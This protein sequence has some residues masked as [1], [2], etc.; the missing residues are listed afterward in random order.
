[1]ITATRRCGCPPKDIFLSTP[2]SPSKPCCCAH[3]SSPQHKPSAALPE[4]SPR[5]EVKSVSEITGT[6]SPYKEIEAI[7]ND[8]R[9][10]LRIQKL[11]LQ[12]EWDPPCDCGTGS[13]EEDRASATRPAAIESSTSA[14]SYSEGVVFRKA[15]EKSKPSSVHQERI[16]EPG[17]SSRRT[18]T[19]VSH[20]DGET[21]PPGIVPAAALSEEDRREKRD[22]IER[23][24]TPRTIDLEENPNLFVLKIRRKSETAEGRE[25]I[26]L[27]FRTPRPWMARPRALGK[28]TRP[29]ID[30]SLAR[31]EEI[32]VEVGNKNGKRHSK[33][34][35]GKGRKEKKGKIGKK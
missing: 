29:V 32:R 12:E 24:R 7:I 23:A 15:E 34:S 2:E 27:E 5:P 9:M 14:G 16:V 25:N 35:N 17:G 30:R 8:N 19:V 10:V 4:R 22:K 26:D 33:G 31:E 13:P 11:P 3:Q 21:G 18:I 28:V 6:G 1:M 20:P